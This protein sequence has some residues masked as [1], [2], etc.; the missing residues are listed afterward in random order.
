MKAHFENGGGGKLRLSRHE[1]KMGGNF[2]ND[3]GSEVLCV[4]DIYVIEK[5]NFFGRGK[6]KFLL[7][8]EAS[9]LFIYKLVF[10]PRSHLRILRKLFQYVPLSWI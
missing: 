7:Y 9:N 4:K 8:S 3:G 1:K 6:W 5:R 2:Q 10:C